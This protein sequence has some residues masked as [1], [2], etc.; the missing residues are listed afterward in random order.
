M[1]EGERVNSFYIEGCEIKGISGF[2]VEDETIEEFV[3]QNTVI[4][5]SDCFTMT[6][7]CKINRMAFYKVIGLW[8]WAIV[9]CPNKR[10]VHLMKNGKN[11]KVKMK[12]FRRGLRII[13]GVLAGV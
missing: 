8:D 7:T 9:N 10:V 5:F 11:G 12:N 6:A 13:E 3:R 1:G 2:A 4:K